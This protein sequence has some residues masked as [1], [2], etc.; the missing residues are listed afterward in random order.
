M[1]KINGMTDDVFV[2]ATV[3]TALPVSSF[4]QNSLLTIDINCT[5]NEFIGF[6]TAVT[7]TTSSVDG[8]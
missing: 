8:D 5:T 1:T 2:I 7:V 4:E 3:P 6:D